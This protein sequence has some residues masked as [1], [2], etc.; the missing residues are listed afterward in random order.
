[1]WRRVVKV[2]FLLFVNCVDGG[3]IV[4]FVVPLLGPSVLVLLLRRPPLCR[5]QRSHCR[6]TTPPI[7][8]KV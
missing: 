1:M 4:V 5:F 7:I 3:L 6:H 2:R 8:P